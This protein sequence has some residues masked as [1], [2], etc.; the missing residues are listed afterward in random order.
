MCHNSLYFVRGVVMPVQDQKNALPVAACCFWDVA[1]Q[2]F[3]AIR[4]E[5]LN[6]LR[7]IIS[8]L[9]LSVLVEASSDDALTA[10]FT[11]IWDGLK[12]KKIKKIVIGY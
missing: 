12:L 4:H 10:R 6:Q 2:C 7:C 5:Y 3:I 11:H 8:P 9:E 1:Q